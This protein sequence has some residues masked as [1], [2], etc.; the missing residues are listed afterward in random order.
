MSQPKALLRVFTK[1]GPLIALAIAGFMLLG[2]LG[3]ASAQFFNFGGPQQRQ[4]PQRGG[5]GAGG[6]WFGNDI[7]APFQE[8]PGR[9]AARFAPRRPAMREDFSRAPPAEKRN[10][11][12]ERNVLVLGDAMADW[13]ASG[14][15]DAYAEQPDMG[16]I[17]KHKTVSGLIRYAATNRKARGLGKPE[18]FM[19]LGFIQ[20]CG[21]SR[22]GNFLLER[23][24]RRDR[25]RMKL[26]DIKLELRRRMHQPIPVQGKWLR[27]VLQLWGLFE[28]ARPDLL[29]RRV[30]QRHEMCASGKS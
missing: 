26:Q 10:G 22:R 30:R 9:P 12:P 16:V 13:L 17:R 24:T 28:F 3:P 19:F 29:A 15:E 14:L 18:T 21:K 23:K 1:T 2:I 27:A 7:F 4:R 8:A 11:V 6:G 25:L 20:I 5:V